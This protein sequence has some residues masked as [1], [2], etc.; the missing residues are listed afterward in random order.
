MLFHFTFYFIL[1]LILSHTSI[2]PLTVPVNFPPIFSSLASFSWLWFWPLLTIFL[3]LP[4][5]S[6]CIKLPISSAQIPPTGSQVPTTFQ[7]IAK[8][9]G[10]RSTLL[11][12][13]V[14]INPHPIKQSLSSIQSAVHPASVTFFVTRGVT[15]INKYKSIQH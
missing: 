15:E 14:Q 2:T 1:N 4:S 6:H 11:T 13:T 3:C 7:G 12:L 8:G 5:R 10:T 9:Q